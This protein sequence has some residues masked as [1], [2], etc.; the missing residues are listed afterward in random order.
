MALSPQQIAGQTSVLCKFIKPD[1]DSAFGSAGE[2]FK[3][4]GLDSSLA[5]LSNYAGLLGPVSKSYKLVPISSAPID[6]KQDLC[7]FK[8]KN[9]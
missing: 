1:Y 6:I 9:S 3:N 2:F 8:R 4:T 5:N 7:I